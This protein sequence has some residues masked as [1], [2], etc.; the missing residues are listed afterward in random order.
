MKCPFCDK[1]N[2]KVLESRITENGQSI[3]RRRECL[4]CKHRFTSYERIEEKPFWVIKRS[5]HKESY[6]REKLLSG[7]LRAC[8]KRPINMDKI[9]KMVSNVEEELQHEKG[10]EVKSSKIGEITLNRLSKL[11]QVAYIRFASVYKQFKNVAEFVKF[12]NKTKR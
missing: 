1:D 12:I 11:D 10:R 8:H 9:E 2:D 5:G 4:S 7:V 3:R 6:N